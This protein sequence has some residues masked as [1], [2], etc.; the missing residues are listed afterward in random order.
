MNWLAGVSPCPAARRLRRSL[1]KSHICIPYSLRFAARAMPVSRTKHKAKLEVAGILRQESPFNGGHATF[2]KSGKVSGQSTG[3]RE[4]KDLWCACWELGFKP[5]MQQLLNYTKWNSFPG[6]RLP[7]SP[8]PAQ[9]PAIR[10]HFS[11]VLKSIFQKRQ[12]VSFPFT[13]LSNR[14]LLL[15]LFFA[16]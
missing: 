1:Q 6:S 5:P 15:F 7:V 2:C 16:L 12:T 8:Q 4:T 3:Q 11:F 13:E 10:A 9:Q 14:D